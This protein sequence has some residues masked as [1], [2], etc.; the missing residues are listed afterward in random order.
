VQQAVDAGVTFMDNAS[1]YHEGRSETLM[2]EALRGRR[3]E[4]FLMTK[5]CTHGHGRK[6]AMRHSSSRSGA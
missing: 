3:D 2:G 4:V 5:V 6:I 1:E